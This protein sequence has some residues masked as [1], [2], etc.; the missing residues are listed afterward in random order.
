MKPKLFSTVEKW[1][2]SMKSLLSF[3][4]AFVL[5][6]SLAACT[7]ANNTQSAV[8]ASSSQQTA[9]SSEAVSEASSVSIPDDGWRALEQEE[10]LALMDQ[11]GASEINGDG[12]QTTWAAKKR[13]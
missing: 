6:G 3:I 2:C 13:G 12:K 4:A 5:V 9:S 11:L 1:G 8:P 7:A 10:I